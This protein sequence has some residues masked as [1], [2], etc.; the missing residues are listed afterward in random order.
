MY[1]IGI[2]YQ[3]SISI[4][5]NGLNQTAILL[6]KMFHA[7]G[8]FEIVFVNI[9][10]M[11]SIIWWDDYPTV[12]WATTNVLY[13][14]HG[15][16]LLID[17]D[18]RVSA[19]ARASAAKDSIVF[20]RT[21][22][23]FTEMDR[24][25]YLDTP[26]I[27]RDFCNVKEIWCWDAL[28]PQETIPSIQ[29]LFMAPIRRIPFFWETIYDI[30]ETSTYN[31]AMKWTVHV[32]EKN[33]ENTG[34]S[35]IP[36][37]AIY[38]MVSSRT[39]DAFYQIHNMEHLIHNRFLQE[40]ILN[41][42]GTATLPI[43]FEKTQLYSQWLLGNH[44]LFSHSRF[45]PL[46]ISLLD[47]IWLGVPTIHNSTL[48]RDLH[49]T[50]HNTFYTGNSISGIAAAFND[51]VTSPEKWYS[52]VHAIRT[53]IKETYGVHTVLDKWT[54]ILADVLTK[55]LS[56]NVVMTKDV[57]TKDVSENVV[58]TKDVSENVVI[59]KDVMT[60]D[61]MT[62]DVITLHISFTDMWPGFNIDKNF[63]T[64]ALRHYYPH[65]SIITSNRYNTL[66]DILIFGPYSNDWKQA[67]S[68]IPKIYFS[69]ENW[70]NPTD[71]SITLHITSN[72]VQ[73]AKHFRIP[74]WMTFIDWFSE[75][76]TMPPMN[77][78]NPIRIP[79]HFAMT[80]HPIPFSDR[81][82]FCAFVV[83]NPICYVRNQTFEA[84]NAYK[85]VN[86]GGALFNN[87]GEQLALKYPGG[88]CGDI[89]KHHFF[90]KHKFSISFENSQA[91]GYITEK[92]L[93]AKMAGCVPLYWGDKDTDTDFAPNSFINASST[94]DP[95]IMLSIIKKLESNPTICS[96]IAATPILNEE[97][98]QKALTTI[99]N[100]C[101]KIIGLK[102]S[103]VNNMNINNIIGINR[104][105]GINGIND[106]YI[107]N[108]DKRADRWQSLMKAEPHLNNIA[109][110]I[111]AID[112]KTLQ[113]SSSIY[114]L[115]K[116]NEY[117]WKKA[118][119]GCMLSHVSIWSK[120]A[121]KN[122]GYYLVLEDDVRFISGWMTIW[123]DCMRTIPADADLLYLGGVLPPNKPALPLAS[124]S[125]NQCWD[126]IIHNNY[127]CAFQP[128]FHFCAYSY[129]LTPRAAKKLIRFIY[130]SG[131]GL[132][133]ASDHLLGHPDAG[134]I[135]Y[136][137]HIPLT[138]CF[139]EADEAYLQSEFND[140]YR[141]DTFDSDIWNNTECFTHTD[142]LP[143][144]R[145]MTIYSMSKDDVMETQWLQD[146]FQRDITYTSLHQL[147]KP[148]S[149][150]LVQRPWLNEW[151]TYFKKLDA[152]QIPF[153]VIHLSDE[154]LVDDITFY[155][156][157]SC[158]G[159]IRNYYR[160]D[161]QALPNIF[162][163]PLGYHY[164][165]IASLKKYGERDLLWSFHGT[166]WFKRDEL[167]QSIMSFVPNNCHLQ[168]DWK[169]STATD[170][171]TY[172]NILSNSKFCPI[173]R[174]NHVETFRLYE[175]LEAGCLPI[176]FIS[177]ETWEAWID[178]N[179]GISSLYAWKNPEA[180]LKCTDDLEQI[181]STLMNNWA[182]WKNR[183][184]NTINAL[185][186]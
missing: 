63:I 95:T 101:E 7:I 125:V 131:R 110:R 173:L 107:L 168:P 23:Q 48:L 52:T 30:S 113:M 176:T 160:A 76:K 54:S 64:D 148:H 34:S 138:Y 111:S 17:I 162:T 97:K 61:V 183:I 145:N 154:F 20:M 116:D 151:N 186:N 163:I 84:I 142:L 10:N 29:T 50:L 123:D 82:E 135:K 56:E 45:V 96:T 178:E 33:M 165:S 169:H 164:K 153:Y 2:T 104:I 181:R 66:T 53:T 167:L 133:T 124:Y 166:S 27:P 72:T 26:Y 40:N 4:Y 11:E 132:F 109:K 73:G 68:T 81:T 9:K 59:T 85:R 155:S 55:D 134:L 177:D 8:K 172:L 91:S 126:R 147:A 47:A 5:T 128:V 21:F 6:G 144:Q 106:V 12:S 157:S 161:C 16:D 80:P 44:I 158:K 62:K 32:A 90:A 83:S 119:I 18:G 171:H 93:H 36:L 150:H 98:K 159:V 65:I 39:I 137:T 156:F 13:K 179:L 114:K 184:R 46:R 112:G 43:T 25:V 103:L 88:G 139:Q 51:F 174:G 57:M 35:I 37:V 3:P 129:I 185:C 28:N 77:D 121:Q 69:A 99:H 143:F 100:M 79:L 170:Q 71:T 19:D 140:I 89:S 42:I 118:V 86:S 108:L 60:K 74:T 49:P 120:I 67:P 136:H 180:M 122:D 75:S 24:S 149:W 141:K 38:D 14:T 92:V 94:N 31:S 127:F 87:I 78:D 58:M 1:K 15:L 130:E 146:I 152:A 182:A 105:D 41:A 175:A 22:I 115:F 117:G 102:P 70:A